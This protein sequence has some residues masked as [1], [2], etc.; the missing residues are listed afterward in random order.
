[1]SIK[2]G[3]RITIADRMWCVVND[4]G[5]ILR[6]DAG[7]LAVFSTRDEAKCAVDD[8]WDGHVVRLD[9]LQGEVQ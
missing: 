8:G 1:M 4:H 5:R 9:D 3:D 6:M 2:K 7:A